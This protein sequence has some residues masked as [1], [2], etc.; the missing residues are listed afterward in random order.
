MHEVRSHQNFPE[1]PDV[2]VP[3][4]FIVL[5]LAGLGKTLD[6]FLPPVFPPLAIWFG[7]LITAAAAAIMGYSAICL[8]RVGTTLRPD[9]PST[10]LLTSGPYRRSRNPLYLGMLLL[11]GGAAVILAS[12]GMLSVLP[13]VW[14]ILDNLVVPREERYLRLRFAAAYRAY[15]E[16]V[17]RWL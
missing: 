11:Q 3:P 1:H 5:A 6:L 2:D 14:L 16:A 17:P 4:W 13:I 9:R 8:R 7:V 10:R 15:A 12:P